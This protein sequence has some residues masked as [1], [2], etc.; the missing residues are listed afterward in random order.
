MNRLLLALVISVCGCAAPTAPKPATA[1]GAPATTPAQE[2]APATALSPPVARRDPHVT[3][4]HGQE[5]VDD[6][7][8]LHNKGTPEVEAY[9]NAEN[10]YTAAMLRPI[11]ALRDRIFEE[12]KA[13][14]PATD[15]SVPQRFGN[16]Y[17]YKRVEPGEQY[18]RLCRKPID[19]KVFLPSTPSD[20]PGTEEVLL[21]LEAMGKKTSYLNLAGW[22]VSDDGRLLAYGLDTTGAWRNTLYVRDLS[23]DAPPTKVADS[24]NTWAF[25]AGAKPVLFYTVENEAE[26]RAYRLY[27]HRFDGKPGG[28]DDLVYEEKDGALYLNVGRTFSQRYL[29]LAFW[30][31]TRTEVWLLD[32]NKPFDKWVVVA[33]RQKD[34][35]YFVEDLGD[36]LIILTDG[37]IPET[38]KKAVNRRLMR[39]P[40]KTP[41]REH[42]K[43]LIPHRDDVFL[44][45][46]LSHPQGIA[47]NERIDGSNQ[48]AIFDPRTKRRTSVPL[49]EAV[50]AAFFDTAGPGVPALRF[51]F[52]SPIRPVST[53]DYRFDTRQVE[54]RKA[55]VLPTY[56]PA[57]FEIDRVSAPTRDGKTVTINVVH[58]RG[59]KPRPGGHPLVLEGYGAYGS[60]YSGFDERDVSMFEHDLVVAYAQIRGGGERGKTWHDQGRLMN[61]LNTFNDYIDAAEHLI[62]VGWAA[63]KQLGAYGASA[64]GLLMGGI[65]NMRPDLWRA[66]VARVP[67]VDLMNTMLND[68]LPLTILEYDEWGNPNEPAAFAYMRRYSPYDNITKQAYPNLLVLTSYND[69]QVMYWEPAKY[70][71]KLRATKTDDNLLLLHTNLDPAGHGGKSGRYNSFADPALLTAFFLWQLQPG[72]GYAK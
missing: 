24:T 20:I 11:A 2:S 57:R 42:W 30:S 31:L 21:D 53:Y 10:G 29:Q 56:D 55:R 33:P 22:E 27:R 12:M 43:E 70:V 52:S 39:A 23:S 19:S 35:F 5:L 50:G 9:L 49:P 40:I 25:S 17:Y 3:K 63:P 34:E 58:K 16:F 60:V 8:W 44:Q 51:T 14:V 6:Y 66:V 69:S 64:G 41:G 47:L 26:K 59:L 7:R 68:K 13:R 62:K 36:E 4:L 18:G 15:S 54:L 61:K 48:L 46:Y 38:G 45:G 71:A 72:G 28:A 37:V 32:A 67:F 65:T 1:T